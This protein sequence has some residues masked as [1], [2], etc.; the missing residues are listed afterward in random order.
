VF[1][2]SALAIAICLIVLFPA[3]ASAVQATDDI[4]WPA[5]G[6]FPAYPPEPDERRVRLSASGEVY[7]DSN[8]FRLSDSVNPQTIIGTSNESDVVRRLGLGLKGDFPISRQRLLLDATIDDYHFDNFSF[9]DYDAYLVGAAWKWAVASDWSGDISYAKTRYLAPLSELQLPIK[10]LITDDRAN[11]G[12]GYLLTPRWR[13]RGAVDWYK[14]EHSNPTRTTLDVNIAAATA[15]LDY[16]TPAGNSV[17]AQTKYSNARYPN[18]TEFVPGIPVDNDYHEIE[19]SAVMHWIVTGLSVFDGRLGYTSRTYA[20]VAQRDFHG[21]TGRLSF[22]WTPGAKTLINFAGWREIRASEDLTASYVVSNG[23][24]VG[25]SWAPASKLVFG[26]RLVYERRQY[27]GSPGLVLVAAP[28]RKDTVRGASIS[29]GYTPW[30]DVE[31]AV[32]AEA[33]KRTSNVDFRDYQYNLISANVQF[34]F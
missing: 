20:E 7:R 15:G 31:F 21:G 10:D 3:A 11:A 24:S 6:V 28:Q 18:P 32:S 34:S 16:V 30:R 8:L 12:A 25:P 19:T 14:S 9:L 2:C 17:G 13:V 27:E 26:A 4:H 22:D 33:G 5:L 29:L 1:G 23:V